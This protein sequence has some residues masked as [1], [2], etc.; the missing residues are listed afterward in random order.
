MFSEKFKLDWDKPILYEG[1]GITKEKKDKI[2]NRMRIT[3]SFKPK[4]IPVI[5]SLLNDP[6]FT[7]LEKAFGMFALGKIEGMATLILV[8]KLKFRFGDILNT[9][10]QVLLSIF[11]KGL[12]GQYNRNPKVRF[13]K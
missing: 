10:Q 11:I 8:A 13:E 2:L 7:D 1:F 6:E 4:F 3:A 12:A 5:E 9:P